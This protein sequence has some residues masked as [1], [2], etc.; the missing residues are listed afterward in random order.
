MIRTL[1]LATAMAMA[2]AFSASAETAAGSPA[3][4]GNLF[5]ENQ[6]RV[7]LSRLGYVGISRL[8]KDE[9]GVW[10]GYA[11]KDGKPRTVAV[12]IKAVARN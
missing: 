9:N 8:T 3:A 11:L 4:R 2:L 7:H 12:D 6:A 1:S 5:T 10:H